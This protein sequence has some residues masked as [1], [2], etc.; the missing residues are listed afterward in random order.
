[1]DSSRVDRY[2]DKLVF[3]RRYC[4]WL[5]EW[6]TG[7]SIEDLLQSQAFKDIMGIYHTYQLASQ[8]V[9]DLAAMIVKDLKIPVKDDYTNL[10]ILVENRIL[11]KEYNPVLKRMRGLRNRIAHDYNGLIDEVAYPGIREIQ[12]ELVEFAKYIEHWLSE[13]IK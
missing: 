11:P 7:V 9:T 8:V 13:A 3:L 4:Q 1:M 12:P 2:R 10:Q 6:T 5:E